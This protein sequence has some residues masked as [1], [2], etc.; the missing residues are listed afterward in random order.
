M[1]KIKE[2]TRVPIP[3]EPGPRIK[4]EEQNDQDNASRGLVSA[5][6]PQRVDLLPLL[7]EALGLKA[8]SGGAGSSALRGRNWPSLWIEHP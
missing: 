6:H 3:A 2:E 7:V 4:D 8:C 5:I 1:L